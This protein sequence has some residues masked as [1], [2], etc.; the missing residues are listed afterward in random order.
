MQVI[1]GSRGEGMVDGTCQK[2]RFNDCNGLA[3]TIDPSLG[4]VLYVCD[5][6]NCL[7]RRIELSHDRVSTVA[8]SGLLPGNVDGP[9][10]K[11]RLYCPEFC[12]WDRGPHLTTNHNPESQRQRQRLY[13]SSCDTIRRYDC[14]TGF[15]HT[16]QLPPHPLMRYYF[17]GLKCLPNGQL[18]V[19][20]GRAMMVIYVIDPVSGRM[21]GLNGLNESNAS[22]DEPNAPFVS[23]GPLKTFRFKICMGL[24]VMD[25]EC[26]I[27]VAEYSTGAIRRVQLSDAY[28]Y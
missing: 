10:S 14:D 18:I 7:L 27:Y 21:H 13:I 15:L 4:P 28:F 16:V 1:A 2:A 20:C 9:V 22:S 26:A 23:S 5:V 3:S 24:E 8:G 6:G 17:S 12:C 25:E 11:S 19:P